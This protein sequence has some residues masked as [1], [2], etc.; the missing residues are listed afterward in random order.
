MTIQQ[1]LAEIQVRIA[2]ACTKSLRGQAVE[3]LAVSK[4]HGADA[5]R[6]AIVV[7]QMVFAENRVQ[8]AMEKFPVLRE[9]YPDMR[10]HLIGMLQTNKV[11][12]AVALFDAVHAIDR[13]AIA[14]KLANEMQ[15]QNR[16]L[17]CFIQVNTGAEPQK[18]GVMIADLP[19]LLRFCRED[20]GLGI[21]GLMCIPPLA[22]DPS[23]H[24]KLL[25]ELA[26]EYQLLL[27]SMGMSADFETAI[28]LGA[29]HVRVGSSIFGER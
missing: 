5:V 4:T 8:E 20:A 22:E 27:L 17:T 1:R 24:F 7:G 23:P 29:T 13:Q 19:E 3:L 11:R 6:E 25:A 10:L 2:A 12:D 26:D 28:R 9:A 15:K 16:N 18:A 14:A 21:K